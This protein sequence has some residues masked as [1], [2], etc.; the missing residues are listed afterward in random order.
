[1]TEHEYEEWFNKY[2]GEVESLHRIHLRKGYYPLFPV[3][4]IDGA[5]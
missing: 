2:L 3:N 4:Y 5:G 1:M